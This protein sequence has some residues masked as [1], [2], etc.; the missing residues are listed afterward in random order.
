MPD[1][2]YCQV[3][4]IICTNT[5]N[6]TTGGVLD[7][8]EPDLGTETITGY[9]VTTDT[10]VRTETMVTV[11]E[12]KTSTLEQATTTMEEVTT[13]VYEPGEYEHFQRM[14][15]PLIIH[16]ETKANEQVRI[17]IEDMRSK[18]LGMEGVKIDPR[19]E[20]VAALDII[21]KAIE[22]ALDQATQ[23]GAYSSRLDSTEDT[24]VTRE[25]N[26]QGAESTI[27]DADMA[28]EMMSYV[29]NNLLSQTAQSMLAQ[30]NQ[31]ASSVLGLLQ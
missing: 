19:D 10:Y 4:Q 6:A 7:L 8:T 12:T 31:S 24:L 5:A 30:A 16:T 18:A 11:T 17:F 29:R 15:N 20:A 23:I 13:T 22:Y 25:E 9:E 14:N 3:G 28:R 1:A 21:D 2:N 27:R 26:T